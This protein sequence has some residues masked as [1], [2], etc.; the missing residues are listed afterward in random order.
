MFLLLAAPILAAP[1]AWW[2]DPQT[3]VLD[4]ANP[5]TLEDNYA[6][7]NLGQLKH[8][9]KQAKAHLD[10]NLPGGAGTSI[11]TVVAGFGGNLTAEQ[12]LANYAPINLGQLKSVA[13]PFYDRLLSVSYD[14]KANLIAHGYPS[15]W[16]SNYPWSPTTP[17]EE[18]YAPANLG[19]L[20]MAFSFNLSALPD[21][22]PEWWQR[23][24]FNGQTGIDM[25]GDSD[26]DGIVNAKEFAL[27]TNPTTA[28]GDLDGDGMSDFTEI[29]SGENPSVSDLARSGNNPLGLIVY[30]SL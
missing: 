16:T 7:A 10:A 12:R 6:P 26:L 23:Y 13:K 4:T 11:S 21:Q 15:S 28:N 29:S 9:A 1:P 19:Q 8:V 30:T 25:E 17:V 27:G 24:Y 14:T 22:L 20:K 5:A 18:N 3:Q 2:S